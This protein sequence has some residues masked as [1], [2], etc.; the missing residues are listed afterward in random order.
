MNGVVEFPPNSASSRPV[1]LMADL[2]RRIVYQYGKDRP[3]LRR[4]MAE[5]QMVIGIASIYLDFKEIDRV[6]HLAVV[7]EN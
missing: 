4:L 6:V 7:E 3:K 5:L 2:R 1:E